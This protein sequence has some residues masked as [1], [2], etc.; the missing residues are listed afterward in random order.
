MASRFESQPTTARRGVPSAD[1]LTSAC[2]PDMV[3]F[4]DRLSDE[5]AAL[6]GKP[7]EA[8]VA[9]V[10]EL[11]EEFCRNKFRDDLTMVAVQADKAVP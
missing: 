3:Y 6:A 2:G 1:G 11:V 8:L 9:G 4:E 10:R 5:L 7:P